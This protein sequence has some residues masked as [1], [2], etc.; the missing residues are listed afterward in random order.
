MKETADNC[1]G[2]TTITVRCC[3][4]RIAD[5]RRPTQAEIDGRHVA[6]GLEDSLSSAAA[7]LAYSNA[8]RSP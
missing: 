8:S 1:S 2:T 5:F 6:V 4:G 3:A 7:K